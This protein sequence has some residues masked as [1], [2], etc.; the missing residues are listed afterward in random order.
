MRELMENMQKEKENILKQNTMLKQ[1]LGE[2]EQ[3]IGKLMG[4]ELQ[5]DED[6]DEEEEEEEEKVND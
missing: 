4:G 6:E 3:L 2:S 1:K 5:E